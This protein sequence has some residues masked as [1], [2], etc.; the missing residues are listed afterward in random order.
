MGRVF[1]LINTASMAMASGGMVAFGGIADSL[2]VVI[3]ISMIGVVFLTTGMIVM[4]SHRSATDEREILTMDPVNS[5]VRL[6]SKKEWLPLRIV[7]STPSIKRTWRVNDR[8]IQTVYPYSSGEKP[9][10]I[11]HRPSRAPPLYTHNPLRRLFK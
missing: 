8:W 7:S 11:P 5:A 3:G 9:D 1:T 6:E 10:V 2:G 4:I